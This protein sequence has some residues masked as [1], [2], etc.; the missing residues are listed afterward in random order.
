MHDWNDEDCAKILVHL[1]DAMDTE[2]VLLIS[3]I[4][5]PDRVQTEDTYVY[6]MDLTM[7]MF[8]GK[9]RSAKDWH[10]LLDMSG[11]ELVKIWESTIG[12]Q[13][14]VEGRKKRV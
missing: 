10:Q 9:E 2:S 1:A 6:W 7:L 8:A 5:V 14:V 4:V 3:E 13:C 12:T 11:L